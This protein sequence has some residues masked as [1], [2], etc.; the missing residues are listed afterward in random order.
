MDK[1]RNLGWI[2]LSVS[3]NWQCCRDGSNCARNLGPLSF[4][5]DE[6][7]QGGVGKKPYSKKLKNT[8]DLQARMLVAR[9]YEH[10]EKVL[11]E[12][13]DKLSLVAES[14]LTKETLNY[15]DIVKLIG[16]PPFGEKKIV[17]IIDF[18]P[19]ESSKDAQTHQDPTNQDPPSDNPEPTPPRSPES[20]TV[21]PK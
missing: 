17:D 20:V 12:N 18:G 13:R 16:P 2:L 8:I 10:T 21:S 7:T 15:T 9:A 6:E 5:A 11:N 1:L 3:V 19:A 4:P 14:L